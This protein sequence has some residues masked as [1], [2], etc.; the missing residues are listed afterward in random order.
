MVHHQY[1]ALR[2]VANRILSCVDE[3]EK[4]QM[5]EQLMGVGGGEGSQMR[6]P[7]VPSRTFRVLCSV[8]GMPKGL[9]GRAKGVWPIGNNG[10]ELAISMGTHSS[11]M[12]RVVSCLRAD[13]RGMKAQVKF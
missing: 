13:L 6:S 4:S 11:E 1:R 12:L 9:S 3:D 7:R 2:R 10:E 8:S 5:A